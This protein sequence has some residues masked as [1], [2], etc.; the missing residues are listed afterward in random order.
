MKLETAKKIVAMDEKIKATEQAI[1][2]FGNEEMYPRI[3]FTHDRSATMTLLENMI[4][5]TKET[6]DREI[7]DQIM[8]RLKE[9]LEILQEQLKEF[10]NE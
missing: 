9:K 6:F 2:Y 7:H 8:K 10:E 3:S 4:D 1:K 5:F